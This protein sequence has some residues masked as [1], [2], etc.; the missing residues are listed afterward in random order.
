[1]PEDL[2]AVLGDLPP[3]TQAALARIGARYSPT[4]IASVMSGV[5]TAVEELQQ[6]GEGGAI[7]A[8][9]LDAGGNLV[10][11]SPGLV[12]T[13]RQAGPAVQ[14]FIA[15]AT[16]QA[17]LVQLAGAGLGL[18]RTFSAEVIAGAIGQAVEQGG[19]ASTAAAILEVAPAAAWGSRYGAVQSVIRQAPGFGLTSGPDVQLFIVLAQEYAPGALLG[20]QS[21][22]FPADDAALIGR[23]QTYAGLSSARPTNGTSTSSY[24][25]FLED[26]RAIPTTVTAPV[27]PTAAPTTDATAGMEDST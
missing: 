15:D 21:A 8:Q 26:I 20:E 10:P 4:A 24:R 5:R 19:T 16:G 17:D 12:A 1:V 7:P 23:V 11:N 6:R 13:V 9:F 27:V 3:A 18:Q 25:N 2:P 14:P 22:E